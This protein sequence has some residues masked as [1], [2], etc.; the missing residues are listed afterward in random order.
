M[1]IP[2]KATHPAD[3]SKLNAGQTYFTHNSRLGARF[4]INNFYG[5]I[6]ATTF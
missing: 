2:T 4:V 1:S 6:N 5:V 3:G